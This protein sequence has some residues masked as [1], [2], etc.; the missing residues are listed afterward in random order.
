MEVK[1]GPYL[2]YFIRI[3]DD[4][5]IDKPSILGHCWGNIAFGW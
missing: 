4:L 2:P 1:M 3:I 5:I